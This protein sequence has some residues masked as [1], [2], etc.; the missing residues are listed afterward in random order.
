[1]SMGRLISSLMRN[2]ESVAKSTTT[3]VNGG[4]TGSES[5]TNTSTNVSTTNVLTT[6]HGKQEKTP[7]ETNLENSI[8]I[9]RIFL[10][11]GHDSSVM[12][13]IEIIG[14]SAKRWPP[15]VSHVA[16]ELWELPVV[17][18]DPRS[19]DE[20]FFVRVLYNREEIPFVISQNY[21]HEVVHQHFH[22]NSENFPNPSGI[23]S[24]IPA[25]SAAPSLFLGRYPSLAQWKREIANPY[26]LSPKEYRAFC[27]SGIPES[28]SPS[29]PGDK[30]IE[31]KSQKIP[32]GG[33]S[34]VGDETDD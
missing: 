22:S 13:I 28:Q 3:V 10:F 9:P 24:E 23:P 17:Q 7:F 32:T 27:A 29:A 25:T 14:Q 2:M 11:S 15:Y 26:L 19:W 18:N 33:A 5:L 16:I 8:P 1:M 4:V 30:P 31:S 20:R 6:T 12:P 34:A 21:Q